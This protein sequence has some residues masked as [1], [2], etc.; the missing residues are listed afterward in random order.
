MSFALTNLAR[1]N[2]V[3][4]MECTGLNAGIHSV[5]LQ[6]T[7]DI[8]GL[9][10]YWRSLTSTV[11]SSGDTSFSASAGKR[12]FVRSSAYENVIPDEYESIS[13][14][15]TFHRTSVRKYDA[16]LEKTMFAWFGRRPM[17]L[18]SIGSNASSPKSGSSASI[19]LFSK[20]IVSFNALYVG[21][22]AIATSASVTRQK[23]KHNINS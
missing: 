1:S 2:C 14:W 11:T 19:T 21:S 18:G 6:P 8:T 16:G 13:F 7:P 15:T 3:R 23:R 10:I 9:G 17:L 12:V 20:P 22:S 4:S 5:C